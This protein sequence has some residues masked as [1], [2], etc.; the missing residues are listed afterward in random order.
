MPLTITPIFRQSGSAGGTGL[1]S[2]SFAVS[3]TID[4]SSWSSVQMWSLAA[5]GIAGTASLGI[6]AMPASIFQG[7]NAEPYTPFNIISTLAVP[8][9]VNGVDSPTTSSIIPITGKWMAVSFEATSGSTAT[10]TG[11]AYITLTFR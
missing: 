2:G 9:A 4:V 3:E 11:S 7:S 5:D 8:E 1:P 10:T 6:Q